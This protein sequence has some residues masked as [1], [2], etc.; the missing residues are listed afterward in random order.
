M[1]VDGIEEKYGYDEANELTSIV[2]KHS[3]TT[4]GELDYS[5]NTNSA[6]EATWGSYARTGLPE[7][8]TAAEYNADNEQTERNSKKQTYDN[9]GHLTSDATSEY[10]WNTRGQLTEISGGTKASFSYDPFGRRISKTIAG[11][12]TKVF[13]D[14]PNAVQETQGAATTN[15]LTGLAPDRTFARTTSKGT[16]TL[17]T[18][19]L[20]STIALAGSTAKAE[21]SYTYDPFGH[22]TSEGTASENPF[23]YAGSE[24]DGTALYYN[25]ARYYS[26]VASRFIS[27]DPL[28]QEGSGTNLYRYVDNTPTNATDPYG[29]NLTGP[30]PGLTPGSGTSGGTAAPGGT[31]PGGTT[32]VTGG[33]SA[34]SGTGGESGAGNGG[35]AF[36][37]SSGS[38]AGP[39]KGG[40]L[41]EVAHCRNYERLEETEQEIG[42]ER[43][44]QSEE[45][46]TEVK[47]RERTIAV[48]CAWGGGLGAAWGGTAGAPGGPATAGIGAASGFAS[49]CLMGAATESAK[50][51][52]LRAEEL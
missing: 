35:G 26:P 14:G 44:R 12:T 40:G 31:T 8:I 19:A 41:G 24:N 32:G 22:T 1:L 46:N 25:R 52:I 48:G 36:G 17:L 5:Y 43:E 3:S 23:Q 4:L 16:E 18:D 11:T 50:I 20:G 9:D 49:G 38:C 15:L 21:T 39:N 34:P 47:A 13:Y 45:Y 37:P 29:T 42:R 6:R 2:Y 30:S 10:K 33:T 27:Q 51:L 7:A 28:G